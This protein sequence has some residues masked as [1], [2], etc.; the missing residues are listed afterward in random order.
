MKILKVI[1]VLA[2]SEKGWD[3]AAQNA[4]KIASKS[5]RGIKS[6]NIQNMSALVDGKKIVE[7]RINAKL[8][9]EIDK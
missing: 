7:Y 2:S 1:E 8:S 4:V 6:I 9:F 3:D 5:V